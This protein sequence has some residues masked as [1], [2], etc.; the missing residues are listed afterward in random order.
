MP[1][2]RPRPTPIEP[3][4]GQ[5]SV[6]DYPRPPRLS[7]SD[8][9]VI[10]EIGGVEIAHSTRAIR[11]LETGHPPVWYIPPEDVRLER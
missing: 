9:E 5:E 3:G 7:P 11:V 4:P 2:P 10:V 1:A 6:W 8:A